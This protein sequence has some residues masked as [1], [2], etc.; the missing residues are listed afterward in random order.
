MGF[1]I[2]PWI[3]GDEDTYEIFTI[4]SDEKWIPRRYLEKEYNALNDYTVLSDSNPEYDVFA[5]KKDAENSKEVQ[6]DVID[7]PSIIPILEEDTESSIS[8]ISPVDTEAIEQQAVILMQKTEKDI[9]D[10]VCKLINQ[11]ILPPLQETC[12]D[13]DKDH[14]I[15]PPDHLHE[16]YQAKVPTGMVPPIPIEQESTSRTYYYYDPTDHDIEEIGDSV[17]LSVPEKIDSEETDT[18]LSFLTYRELTGY[19]EY[20][21]YYLL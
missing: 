16:P 13:L 7:I 9:V 12:I 19:K 1:Q 6:P 8:S 21:G 4:T 15:P 18:F 14:T 20:D 3:E 5:T 17:H 11:G 2:L 10:N